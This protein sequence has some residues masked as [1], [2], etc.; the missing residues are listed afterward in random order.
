[1]KAIIAAALAASVISLFLFHSQT[2]YT[3]QFET[4]KLKYNKEYTKA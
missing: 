1:M 3:S 4:Y 2:D